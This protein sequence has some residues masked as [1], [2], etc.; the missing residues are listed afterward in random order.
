MIEAP[1][2]TM[3]ELA[4]GP[5]ATA[6]AGPE[7]RYVS[8]ADESCRMFQS[9][10]RERLSHMK[11]WVP[12]AIFIP[13]L[14]VSLA[15]AFRAHAP[16]RVAAFYVLGLLLWTLV[17]Y[18]IHRGSFHTT[19]RVQD[20]PRRIVASLRRDEPVVPNLPTPR[21]RFYF[22]A[23][24]VHHDYPNDSTRLVLAPSVSIPLAVVFYAVFR[25]LFGAATPAA[26]AG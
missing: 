7:V 13:V 10:L 1:L 21:H 26:F 25:L 18:V 24:G 14:G 4:P 9:D 12:H 5:A 17:E 6:N 22:V 8:N 2:E 19:P 20:E 16:A 15:A 3:S 23:H 11:P